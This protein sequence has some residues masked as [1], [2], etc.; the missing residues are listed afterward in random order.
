M[1]RAR[2]GK[3]Q[4]KE[5]FIN[6]PVVLLL[7]ACITQFFFLFHLLGAESKASVCPDGQRLFEDTSTKKLIFPESWIPDKDSPNNLHSE[8]FSRNNLSTIDQELLEGQAATIM[9]HEP[10]WFQR[11]YTLML[12]NTLMN[13]PTGWKLQ[14]FYTGVGQ[15]KSGIDINNGL[16]RMIAQKKVVLTLIP[17]KIWKRKKKYQI[18]TDPWLWENMLTDKVLIFLYTQ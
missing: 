18:M 7:F 8:R 9:L 3:Q 17:E 4:Q 15:S 12:M 10:K 6:I 5:N 1:A 16:Q 13:L 2:R 14:V 11:R